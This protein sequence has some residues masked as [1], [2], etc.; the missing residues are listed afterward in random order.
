MSNGLEFEIPS[1]EQIYEMLIELADRIQRNGL[2]PDVIVGVSRGGW[3]PAR[4]M[5]DLLENPE[6]ANVKAEFYLGVAE[7]KGE[8]VIT[9]PV[10]T[11]VK[12]KKVLVMDDVADTG[13]SLR[14]VKTHLSKEGATD[15]KIAT[16]YYKPWSVLTPDYYRKKTSLWVIF[17][18]ERK[19]TIRNIVKKYE[20]QKKPIEE[21]NKQLVR[22]GLDQKLVDRFIREILEGKREI[23]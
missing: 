18:W 15:I 21:A 5:S 10:S 11:S 16:I 8:P 7:T 17:P 20:Q 9:Q 23:D 12:D 2:E 6:L 3:V 14:L 13:K 22:S 4:I 19:E 1:W